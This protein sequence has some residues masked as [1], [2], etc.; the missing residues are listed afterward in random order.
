MHAPNEHD[1][2]HVRGDE[3]H[4]N[5]PRRRCSRTTPLKRCGAS[6]R[7]TTRP[8]ASATR[9][10]VSDPAVR[11]PSRR[12]PSGDRGEE[13]H[14]H[15][16]SSARRA[17]ALRCGDR[18]RLH[19]VRPIISGF[20]VG[21]H[22]SPRGS[23][24]QTFMKKQLCEFRLVGRGRPQKPRSALE[25][26]PVAKATDRKSD[27]GLRP[28]GCREAS[29]RRQAATTY[30]SFPMTGTGDNSPRATLATT[31]RETSEAEAASRRTTDATDVGAA[32]AIIPAASPTSPMG[33]TTRG[34]HNPSSAATTCSVIHGGSTQ[35]LGNP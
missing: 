26:P 6:S 17:R 34:R 1:V 22:E 16:C 10:P 24:A 23:G 29:Q 13:L 33:S 2:V 18:R 21:L 3:R 30:V 19:D 15:C 12:K 5:Q 32:A 9:L 25:E 8:K 7:T 31:M 11:R 35:E 20:N 14:P 27:A 28:R 4:P